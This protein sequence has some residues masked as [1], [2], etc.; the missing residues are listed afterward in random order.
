MADHIVIVEALT[1]GT[2]LRVVEAATRKAARVTFVTRDKARYVN[3]PLRDLLEPGGRVETYISETRS[4]E[5]LTVL[6]EALGA[7]GAFTLIAPNEQYLLPAATAA[8]KL[9]IPFLPT[10]SVRLTQDKHAFRRACEA[11]DIPAPRSTAAPDVEAA[12]AAAAATGYPVVL[13][14][15]IGTGSYG[16]VSAADEEEVRWHFTEVLAESDGQG[17]VPLVEEFLIGPVVSAEVL[18]TGGVPHVLGISD[19]IMSELPYFMEL[20]I[21]FPVDLSA[22]AHQRIERICADLARL[23]AYENGP[24]HIE[25]ALTADGPKVVEFNPRFAGRNVSTMVSAAL[26]WNVFDGVI[27]SYLGE[28]VHAPEPVGAAAEQAL[29]AKRGG[30]FEGVAG[31]ELAQRVPGL[32]DIHITARSGDELPDAKDQRSEYGTLWCTGATADEAGIRAASA[33]GY[34]RPVFDER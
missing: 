23:M 29:Y 13:K 3:D 31:R 1:S 28:P 6:F 26:D 25:F 14:P 19:R 33:A 20:A 24:A 15:S 5:E 12:V 10:A 9:G 27:A 4:V 21:R 22:D 32:R 18:Y 30:R 8:E 17:G 7:D 11:E 16:V 2:G 34:L